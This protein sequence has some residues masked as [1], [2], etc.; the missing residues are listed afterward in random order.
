MDLSKIDKTW[1]LFIDRDG[2][3]NHEKKENYI[4][5]WQEF[6]F[7]DGVTEAMEILS[8]IF[9]TIIMVTN[10]RGVG[11]GLMT[12]AELHEIHANMQ[13]VLEE[14]SGRIDRIYYCT[15]LDN[16]A[17]E[18]KPNPGMALLA[19]LDYPHIDFTKSIMIGNK[20]SDMIFGRNAGMFT[21]YVDTTNPEVPSPHPAID[22]R[23]KDLPEAADAINA[24]LRKS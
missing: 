1:T 22:L 21:I 7:Y 14:K 2:V 9:P 8:S 17:F 15:S 18:R 23:Y 4:L 11:K 19:K 6:R 5:N 12:A 20:L 24:A 10:Q 16:T 3:I 13:A